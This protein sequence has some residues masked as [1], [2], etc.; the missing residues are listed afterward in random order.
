MIRSLCH[1]HTSMKIISGGQT[2]I[3]QAALRAALHCGF[4][5]GGWCP[6]G[7]K[8]E[9][10]RIP[11][12]FPVRETPGERSPKAPHIPR[13]LRTEWNVRD[14]DGTLILGYAEPVDQ[15]AI[16]PGTLWTYECTKLFSKPTLNCDPDEVNEA[17]VQMIAAWIK[18]SGIHLLNVA[19]PA[20]STRPGIGQL[21][22]IFLVRVFEKLKQD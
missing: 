20:E 21:A 2:G 17:K 3:D 19:G 14:S 13:S 15:Q 11:A 7:G 6:P 18:S 9:S 4:E 10:G 22:E 5:I 1:Y 16:D 12:I 8:C